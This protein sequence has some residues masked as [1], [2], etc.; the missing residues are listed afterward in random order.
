[1]SEN[2]R[3]TVYL[4]HTFSS[5]VLFFRGHNIPRP[6]TLVSSLHLFSLSLALEF[7]LP[8][9]FSDALPY[10]QTHTLLFNVIP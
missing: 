4:M 6:I 5:K 1:M 7:S 3:R 8:C 2:L 9:F 10:P